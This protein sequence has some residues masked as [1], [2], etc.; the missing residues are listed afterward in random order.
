MS[1]MT[2]LR[3]D[4]FKVVYWKRKGQ[5][6]VYIVLQHLNDWDFLEKNCHKNPKLPIT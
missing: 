6:Y 1:H 5:F 2:F 3:L 4:F